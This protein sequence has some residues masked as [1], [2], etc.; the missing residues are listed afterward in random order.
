MKDKE[1]GDIAQTPDNIRAI[2]THLVEPQ[3]THVSY[4]PKNEGD[5][6]L[7][8]GD[9]EHFSDRAIYSLDRTQN[10]DKVQEKKVNPKD[11]LRELK[12]N[13]TSIDFNTNY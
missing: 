7:D 9:L 8:G 4:F 5:V 6:S 10:L 2:K 13:N 11:S 3:R 1:I 12:M